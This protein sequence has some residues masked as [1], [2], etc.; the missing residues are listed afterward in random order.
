M[1]HNNPLQ[2]NNLLDN[3]YFQEEN[4]SLSIDYT[5]SHNGY[6][7]MNE[8]IFPTPYEDTSM[9]S[10]HNQ[11]YMTTSTQQ[12]ANGFNTQQTTNGFNTQQSTTGFDTL[13]Q[14]YSPQYD[15]HQVLSTNS[16][17]PVN[18]ISPLS[19]NSPPGIF[20]FDI[21]GF[22]IIVVPV[23]SPIENWNEQDIR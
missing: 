21:P 22:K 17:P 18:N 23:T 4:S 8:N 19:F 20:R 16:L 11:P 13:T 10:H 3:N 2:N 14:L 9:I 6:P 5:Y 7:V 12:T 1:K 15:D